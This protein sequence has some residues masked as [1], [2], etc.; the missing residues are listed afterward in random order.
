[1]KRGGGTWDKLE[2]YE[3][4]IADYNTAID[5]DPNNAVTY[6]KKGVAYEYW[7][8][9]LKKKDNNEEAI[10]KYKDAII[11]YNEAIK[12]DRDFARANTNRKEA[13]TKYLRL[14]YNKDCANNENAKIPTDGDFDKQTEDVLNFIT[15]DKASEECNKIYSD[16]K[17]VLNK[18]YATYLISRGVDK[19]KRGNY[20]EAIANYNTAP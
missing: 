7:G 14:G 12:L 9:S 16:Y 6:N 11:N 5:L 13:A 4:A 18:L 19:R 3:S 2:K 1:M 8:D 20:K 10:K 17:I 15:S